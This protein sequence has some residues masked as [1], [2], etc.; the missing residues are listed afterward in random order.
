M[1]TKEFIE[2]GN[3]LSSLKVDLMNN[4]NVD[5]WVQ[6]RNGHLVEASLYDTDTKKQHWLCTFPFYQID[7]LSEANDKFES[8]KQVIKIYAKAM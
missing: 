6:Y 3:K 1:T 2:L 7:N 4:K 8:L 5:L